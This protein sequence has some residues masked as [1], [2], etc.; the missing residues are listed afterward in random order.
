MKKTLCAL[1][2]ATLLAA[3]GQA[4][5]T[6]APAAAPA[7]AIHADPALWVVKDEDTTIYLFGTVHVLKP[8]TIWLDGGVKKAY[9]SASD[10]VLEII[11]PKPEEMQAK[12]GT[13]GMDPN[14]PPLTQ[15]LSPEL[16]AL[17]EKTT[18]DL[19]V[20]V[21]AFEKFQPWFASVVLSLVAVQK[22][23][24]DPQSGVEVQLAEAVKRDGKTLGELETPDEQLGFF[25]SLPQA[26][27]IALLKGTLEQLPQAR[28]TFGAMVD[29]WARG[30]PEALAALLNQA[31]LSTPDVQKA[32]LRDRNERWANWI[33]ARMK[34]PGVVFIAVGAGH[35][36]GKDSVQ[37]FLKT[38]KLTA[39]RIP[40]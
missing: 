8:G 34:K 28:E 25:A 40:S 38:H 5:T 32:L 27:Q 24:Y 13:L 12:L 15:K 33:D 6:A 35:L 26:S 1:L 29:D 21:P 23:G 30:D 17:Y 7:P 2:G 4:Q 19:G 20:P 16:R 37:D 10:V 11:Q 36:A 31:M 39:T 18:A 22:A 14:G 9:D 3:A